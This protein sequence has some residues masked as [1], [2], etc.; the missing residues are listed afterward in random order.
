MTKNKVMLFKRLVTFPDC[1]QDNL[2]EA[3]SIQRE[4][5]KYGFM[6]DK[7]AFEQLKKTD[8]A[9]IIEFQKEVI[10]FIKEF[11]GGSKD[12]KSL[13]GN[14][15]NDIL[16]V[17]D[18]QAR[19]AV[20]LHYWSHGNFKLVGEPLKDDVF[21]EHEYKLIK[22]VTEEEFLKIFTE[23][24]SS[25]QS[26]SPMD[27]KVLKYFATSGLNITFPSTIPF[28]ENLAIIAS[29]CPQF[30]VKTVVDVLRIAVGFSGG[31]VSLPAV[32]KL[33][34]FKGR[35][36]D[37]RVEERKKF[38]FKLDDLQ[39]ERVL[40]L[41][42]ESNLSLEDLQQGSR[43]NRFIRLAEVL[44]IGESTKTSHPKTTSAFYR[45]RNQIRKGKPDGTPKIRTWYSRVNEAFKVGLEPG[46]NK[47]SERP[48]EFL[49]RID[50]L[51]RKS[52]KSGLD[53]ILRKLYEVGIN[54]SNKV[55]FE[56]Y[57]HF[58]N[59]RVDMKNRSI[60][61]KG[62]RKR[63]PLPDLPKL[64]PEVVDAIQDVVIEIIKEKFKSL[65]P[66]GKVYIDPELK[67][68][69][70]P[71]NMRSL[72]ESLIPVIRGERINIEPG[73]KVIRT[74][75]HWF[76]RYGNQDID[77]HGYL[78]KKDGTSTRFGFNSYQGNSLGCYSG[79]II[80]RKGSCA[81]YNDI[82][83]SNVVK[84][85]YRY[86]IS[87]AHNYRNAS[88]VGMEEVVFGSMYRQTAESSKTWLPESIHT[89]FKVNADCRSVLLGVYDLVDHVFIPLD[90]DFGDF[91]TYMTGSTTGSI[92]K[93]IEPYLTEPKLSV[94]HLLKWHQEARGE[95][96]SIE[97]ADVH[98]MYED[99]KDSYTTVLPYMG[100]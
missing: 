29:L 21:E 73:T 3:M 72:S 57:T 82:I 27:Q 59:R 44:N 23:L 40:N 45:V 10:E 78:V 71:T 26:L 22:G 5:M 70:L 32:P 88:F 28:K 56:V 85:G 61:I 7:S 49:R 51:V 6:L 8:I 17:T 38:I 86:F 74:F 62:A 9:N 48:G 15:P 90:L 60:F 79:D 2:S 24:C 31:D 47:L 46:V 42:E 95:N 68:I 77:L 93:A 13:Y 50:A 83:I 30:T 16:S 84:A 25:G 36:Y 98:F 55:L 76:D 58:E 94:Y 18:S 65:E 67:K 97:E 37:L 89:A 4:L 43:Y 96:S 75:V 100:V 19:F 87:V 52:N 11:L 41:F 80:A 91:N 81:E 69:P 53:Y 1:G 35:L 63:T 66:L 12:F 99:F 20:L 64:K 14:F 39:K 54:S 33:P 92:M 34:K